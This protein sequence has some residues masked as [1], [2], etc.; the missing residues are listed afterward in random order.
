V[1]ADVQALAKKL[2]AQIVA[3]KL[4]PFAGPV[5]D[6]DGKVRVPAGQAIS[7]H[8]L[9]KMDYYVQGVASK[10]PGK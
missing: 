6:Q 2:E 1:P 5:V 9:E 7:D 4:H 3:G 10:M 8:D